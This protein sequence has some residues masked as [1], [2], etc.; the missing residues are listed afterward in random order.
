M[1]HLEQVSP[2]IS[3]SASDYFDKLFYFQALIAT[4]PVGHFVVADR[5]I[6][7]LHRMCN[8]NGESK[9][10]LHNTVAIFAGDI[11]RPRFREKDNQVRLIKSA[12]EQDCLAFMVR[13]YA[14]IFKVNAW[15]EL[16]ALHER[17]LKKETDLKAKREELH[18]M[19]LSEVVVKTKIAH[20]Q[21]RKNVLVRHFL[22]W[23]A[24]IGSQ[25]AVS[26]KYTQ[27]EEMAQRLRRGS[28][29]EAKLETALKAA[30]ENLRLSVLA[31]VPINT[32]ASVSRM[33]RDS[34]AA[35]NWT[36]NICSGEGGRGPAINQF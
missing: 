11:L 19:K 34:P 30:T 25:R 15:R 28:E 26:D 21:F 4:L 10:D 23:H 13:N 6:G 16:N 14:R 33:S 12:A 9:I 8:P 2:I 5:I 22:A 36:K 17:E 24:K 35:P 1:Q 32:S 29:R 27:L 7:L 31:G 20:H 3:D 18:K